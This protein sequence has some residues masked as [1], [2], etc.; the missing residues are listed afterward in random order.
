MALHDLNIEALQAKDPLE[1]ERL[2]SEY[3]DRVLGYIKRRVEDIELATDLTQETFLGAVGSI[4]RFKEQYN[5]EQFLMGIARNKVIDHLRRKRPEI[6]ITDRDDDATGFFGAVPDEGPTGDRLL[7]CRE[8]VNRQRGALIQ[9]LREMSEDLRKEG[10]F[11][12][13]MTI[14]LCFLTNKSHREIA[15]VIGIPQEKAIA[16]VKF[17]AIRELQRRLRKKDARRTLFSGLWETL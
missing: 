14:E 12:R 3:H 15:K 9:C 1:W 17:R 5:I 2:L 4:G 10:E 13:L 16:G 7:E 6:H 11:E 8:R